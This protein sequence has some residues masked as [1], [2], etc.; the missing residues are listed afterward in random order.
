MVETICNKLTLRI[1]KKIP[2]VDDE[3]A[4]IINYGLQLLIGEIPKTFIIMDIAWILG[5]LDLKIL[6]LILMLTYRMY[7]S[8]INFLYRKCYF[9]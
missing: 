3:R 8:N 2:D 4:E 5:V 9:K 7:S 1:R 6:E